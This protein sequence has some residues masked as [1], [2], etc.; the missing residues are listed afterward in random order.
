LVEFYAEK[1]INN[2]PGKV[3]SF[4]L[5]AKTKNNNMTNGNKEITKWKVVK[6]R[7]I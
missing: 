4:E 2:F 5:I 1:W 3:N 7:G 6:H